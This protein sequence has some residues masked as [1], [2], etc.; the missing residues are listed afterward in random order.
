MIRKTSRRNPESIA[1][2]LWGGVWAGLGCVFVEGIL[3]GGFYLFERDGRLFVQTH[4]SFLLVGALV[5]FVAGFGV[6]L[7]SVLELQ[8]WRGK[9]K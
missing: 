2:V 3:V 7:Q 1:D 8:F 4:A 6:T 9:W 5:L